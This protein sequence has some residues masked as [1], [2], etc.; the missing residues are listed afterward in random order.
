M[1]TDSPARFLD[2]PTGHN[3]RDIGGY[4]TSDGRRVKWGRVFRAGY[5]S[6]IDAGDAAQL[7]ALGLHT[8]CDLRANDERLERPTVWHLET[9]TVLW[10]RDH[11]FSAGALGELVLRPDLKSEHTEHSMLEIYRALPHEQVVSYRELLS[12][13][14]Q[15]QVPILFNC[16]AGKD[17]TGLAAALILSILDVPYTVIEADYMLSNK[18]V[19]GLIEFMKSS[20][21]YSDAVTN[22][23]DRVL[24]MMRV[25]PTYLA[26][27]FEVIEREHGSVARYLDEVLGIGADAQAAIRNNLLN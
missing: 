9:P 8:I 3:V 16:S 7:Q 13:I 27:S 15:S 14:A 4:E 25:E 22:R 26:T 12:R 17:R 6:K 21:K 18:V 24:P 10:A 2:L 20:P 11:A 19:D 1:M 23:L 5:M